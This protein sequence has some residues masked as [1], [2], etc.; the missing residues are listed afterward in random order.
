LRPPRTPRTPAGM[1]PRAASRCAVAD[2]VADLVEPVDVGVVADPLRGGQLRA[3]G[4]GSVGDQREA[5]PLE[6]RGDPRGGREPAGDRASSPRTPS[7]SRSP[8]LSHPARLIRPDRADEAVVELAVFDPALHAAAVVAR[9]PGAPMMAPGCARASAVGVR[10]VLP[11][12]RR[13]R[14]ERHLNAQR[15]HGGR[16][17][18]AGAPRAPGSR[19]SACSRDVSRGR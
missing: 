9:L 6:R 15:L 17:Y 12:P 19:T 4:Q 11:P 3:G 8:A 14:H 10:R 5:R 13:D 16:Q 2:V 1:P 7:R 18:A